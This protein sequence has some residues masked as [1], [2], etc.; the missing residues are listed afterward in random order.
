[1]KGDGL[2]LDSAAVVGADIVDGMGIQWSDFLD[3]A[4]F[5]GV[6]DVRSFNNSNAL[7]DIFESGDAD[8]W[9]AASSWPIIRFT[10]DLTTDQRVKGYGLLIVDGDV[11]VNNDKLEWTGLLLVGGTINTADGA[12]IHVKGAAVAGLGCTD[13]ERASGACRSVLDGDHND[14]KYR[15]C[16]ISQAWSRLSYLQPLDDLF[17]EASPEN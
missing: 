2:D 15:P 3:D 16:E 13:A 1:M 17:R 12:H 7:E 9:K 6:S 8:A 14:M 10:G 11:F 5:T 4:Y